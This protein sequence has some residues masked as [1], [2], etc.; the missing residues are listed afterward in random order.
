MQRK[1]K[2][3]IKTKLTIKIKNINKTT[4]LQEKKTA[5]KGIKS[6]HPFM[7][8]FRVCRKELLQ[9]DGSNLTLSFQAIKP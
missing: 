8:I 5:I 4:M 2:P 6:Q 3:K 9:C 1:Q 7:Q